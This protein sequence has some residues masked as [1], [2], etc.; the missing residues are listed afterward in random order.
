MQLPDQGEVAMMPSQGFG[1]GCSVGTVLWDENCGERQL[2]RFGDTFNSRRHS[3]SSHSLDEVVATFN[4]QVPGL[5]SLK[6]PRTAVAPGNLASVGRI[7]AQ[8]NWE[9]QN[10]PHR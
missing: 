3:V 5:R 2:V 4:F 8:M 1:C 6:Q 9:E 10:K 7:L